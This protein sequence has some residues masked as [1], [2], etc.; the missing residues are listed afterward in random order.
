[1]GPQ[2]GLRRKM[3]GVGVLLTGHLWVP[4]RVT[5]ALR[6]NTKLVTL[7]PEDKNVKF[8]TS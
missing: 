6:A 5:S 1:M 7:S 3:V 2:Y 8:Q 4:V